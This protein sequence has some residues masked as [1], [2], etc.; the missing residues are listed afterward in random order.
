MAVIINGDT[1]IDKITDGSI[2]AAD[3]GAGEI[4]DAKLAST[5]DLTGKTVTLPAGV[6]GKILQVVTGTKTDKLSTTSTSYVDVVSASITPSSTSSKILI[7]V[8]LSWCTT[9]HSFAKL[10]RGATSIALGDAAGVREQVSL[11]NGN[12]GATYHIESSS[13]TWL[14]SPSTTSSTTY[15]IQVASA[16]N[17]YTTTV[18]G[19]YTDSD[20]DYMGRT[21]SSITLLEVAG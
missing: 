4:T 19:A 7:L 2:V 6:G 16:Y 21:V 11:Y 20:V 17:S 10:L 3:I 13:L 14:D 1:G 9:G 8:R 5:L 15:K 12:Y 18:N